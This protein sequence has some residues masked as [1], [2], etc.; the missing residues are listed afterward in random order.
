MGAGNDSKPPFASADD[1]FKLY[2]ANSNYEPADPD[3]HY[4]PFRYGDTAFFVLD[5]RRYRSDVTQ[6]NDAAAHTMLG[7]K[8]LLALYDWLG[9]VSYNHD[10]EIPRADM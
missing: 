1:A 2:N 10:F 3:Q 4:Y 5:T 9:K 8:Q 6:Q 7:D